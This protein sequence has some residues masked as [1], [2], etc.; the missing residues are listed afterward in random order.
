VF[1]T[2]TQANTEEN[3]KE[4]FVEEHLRCGSCCYGNEPSLFKLN[5]IKFQRN[6]C[7]KQEQYEVD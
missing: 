4:K 7:L 5:F 6:I 1:E 3:L 2:G